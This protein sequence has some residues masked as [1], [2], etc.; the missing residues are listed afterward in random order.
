MY[1]W[2]S[3]VKDPVQL[4]TRGSAGEHYYL[5]S[6]CWKHLLWEIKAN[7]KSSFVFNQDI[8]KAPSQFFRELLHCSY[9]GTTKTL[10]STALCQEIVWLNQR[11]SK[12]FPWSDGFLRGWKIG[13]EVTL[14]SHRGRKAVRRWSEAAAQSHAL[15]IP[16]QQHSASLARW[17]G[18]QL[19]ANEH[20]MEEVC[21]SLQAWPHWVSKP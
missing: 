12:G 21:N 4:C 9:G 18:S 7:Q 11:G 6:A 10:W 15:A 14:P 20:K 1:I 8:C 13:H 16:G 5:P 19:T 17:A 3:C 2:R